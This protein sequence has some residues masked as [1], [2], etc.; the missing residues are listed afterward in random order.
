MIKIILLPLFWNISPFDFFARVSKSFDRM[1][2]IIIFEIFFF[3]IK[4]YDWYY[5]SEKEN[6]KNN[7]FKYAV[8]NLKL[9]GKK[10]KEPIF[11]NRGS[12]V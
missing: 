10:I 2:K 11:Q 8:K 3:W 7:N 5:Y 4:I 6:F 12:N 1:L 9:H